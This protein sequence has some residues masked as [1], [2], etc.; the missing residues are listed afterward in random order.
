M[1]RI[2]IVMHRSMEN[3][4]ERD[5]LFHTGNLSVRCTDCLAYLQA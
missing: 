3:A 5:C 4:T 2:Q 1:Q